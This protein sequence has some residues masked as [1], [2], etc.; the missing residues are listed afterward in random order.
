MSYYIALVKLTFFKIIK[1]IHSKKRSRLEHQRLQD[2]VFIKYNQALKDR[3]DSKDVIDPIVL[4]NVDDD[5]NEWFLG[6]MGGN[7]DDAEDELVFEDD[8]TMTWGLVEEVTGVG[9]PSHNTRRQAKRGRATHASS[10]SSKEKTRMVIKKEEDE[11]ELYDDDEETDEE[12]EE[13]Y[14]SDDSESEGEEEMEDL[15]NEDDD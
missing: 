14:K 9:E 11:H 12:E 2:L 1:Q 13:I 8:N 5:S 15:G 10:L 7:E 3:F 6:Q 4:K